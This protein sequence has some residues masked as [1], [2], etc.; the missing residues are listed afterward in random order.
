MASGVSANNSELL[1]L[2]LHRS[3]MKVTPIECCQAFHGKLALK[4]PYNCICRPDNWGSMQAGV[5]VYL[6]GQ[7]ELL[8]QRV[9]AQDGAATRPL[10]AGADGEPQSL[11]VATEKI[12][13]LLKDRDSSYKNADCIVQ[14]GGKGAL[15]ASV[16][17]VC[18]RF[19]ASRIVFT[20]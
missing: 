11:E 9:L 6:E 12:Q 20:F 3:R 16:P 13:A 19:D 15:G 4:E 1:I 10:L 18:V 5:T 17:E 2:E 7:P 8:A 14:L